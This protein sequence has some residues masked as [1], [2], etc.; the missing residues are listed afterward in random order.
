VL[1]E[2]ERRLSGADGEVLLHL[3][4]FIAAEG[5]IGHHHLIAVLLLNV[6]EVLRERIGV[7]DVWGLDAVQDHVHDRDD[8]GER[9]LLLPV[10]GA[11]L[12]RLHFLGRQTLLRTQVV[13]GLAKEA[14]RA[15]DAITDA[16]PDMRLDHFDNGTYE[17]A[18]RVILTAVAPGVAHVPDFGFVE[19]RQLVFFGLRAE[20]QLVNMI[21]DLAEVVTALN[22]VLDLAEDLADLVFKGIWAAGLCRKA[23]QIRKELP[24]HKV[25]QVI[26]RHRFVVVA[27][28]VL[29]PRRGPRT[30]AIGTVGNASVLPAL[31][32]GLAALVLLKVVEVF[33]EQQP[34]SLLGVVKLGRA[35]GFLPKD[36]INISKSLFGHKHLSLRVGVQILPKSLVL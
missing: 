28:A 9:L 19:V 27:L 4:A 7:D 29:T 10:E 34:G 25:T 6:G 26:S 12:E 1:K 16:L 11:L 35:A 36:V 3:F 31:Q 15:D 23:V 33:Q 20:A 32:R 22:L 17:R 18:W 21:D 30:P 14:G 8:V 13:K 2:Q 24:V 5:W